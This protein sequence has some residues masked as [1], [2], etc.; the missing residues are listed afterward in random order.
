MAIEDFD[1]ATHP[2]G[3]TFTEDLSSA[4]IEH[5][6]ARIVLEGYFTGIESRETIQFAQGGGINQSVLTFR[7]LWSDDSIEL[8]TTPPWREG[9]P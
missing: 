2:P 3:I 9:E 1:P 6:K 4:I 8:D 7:P 5:Q